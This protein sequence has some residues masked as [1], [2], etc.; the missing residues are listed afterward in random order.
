MP[1]H[2]FSTIMFL[3]FVYLYYPHIVG[4][5]IKKCKKNKLVTYYFLLNLVSPVSY[6]SWSPPRDLTSY[7]RNNSY[8]QGSNF[9]SVVCTCFVFACICI[10]KYTHA[11]IP[12]HTSRFSCVLLSLH[13]ATIKSFYISSHVGISS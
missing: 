8:P 4:K 5:I 2:R 9:K 10:H 7:K 1:K 3:I 13:D 6:G 11:H 12:R